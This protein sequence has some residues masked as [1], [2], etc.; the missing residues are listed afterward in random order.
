MKRILKRFA[1]FMAITLCCAMLVPFVVMADQLPVLSD[2]NNLPEGCLVMGMEDVDR[3]VKGSNS[4][5]LVINERVRQSTSEY[6]RNIF[7]DFSNLPDNTSNYSSKRQDFE[8]RNGRIVQSPGVV[9]T[10]QYTDRVTGPE[11]FLK[12]YTAITDEEYRN[13]SRENTLILL[14]LR[15]LA[16]TRL[17]IV[18]LSMSKP[19]VTSKMSIGTYRYQPQ[20]PTMERYI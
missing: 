18:R 17:F 9:M 10:F 19:K 6:T 20:Y 15:P 2:Y 16:N 7:Y 5:L 3:S 12:Q 14:R 11:E 13:K 8:G 1:G 4:Y